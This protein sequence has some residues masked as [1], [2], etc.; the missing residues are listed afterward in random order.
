M[1]TLSG[2]LAD[3]ISDLLLIE[4]SPR[5]TK[6]AS[7]AE[8]LESDLI[9]G[10]IV[11]EPGGTGAQGQNP[12]IYYETAVGKFPLRRTSSAI[13]EFAPVILALRH[14]CEPGD[15]LIIEEPESHLHPAA[16]RKLAQAMVKLV[17]AGA[18]VLIT[19]HSDFLLDQLSN[20]IRLGAL[21]EETRETRGF[22]R[23]DFLRTREVGVY[24][25]DLDEAQG[26]STV[27]RL[28][29]GSKTGIDTEDFAK[30]NVALYQETVQ[31]ERS[32]P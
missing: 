1:P 25:F 11:I 8:F 15:L 27:K 13:S 4:R 7:I 21:D 5:Q 12:E 24:L 22:D 19:T 32:L 29:V 26:G 6:L 28:R 9:K 10:R 31:L 16:Q 20:F 30:V 3:F 2:V 14:Y 18:R 23:N 17:R